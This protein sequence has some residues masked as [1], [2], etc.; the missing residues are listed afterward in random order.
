MNMPSKRENF[1]YF[2]SPTAVD[3]SVNYRLTMMHHVQIPVA[4]LGA[5][6][7]GN[8]AKAT[9]TDEISTEM[10]QNL[11]NNNILGLLFMHLFKH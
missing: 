4:I 5:T 10:A 2:L 7:V 3:I 9:F 11:E 1:T 6:E 8:K